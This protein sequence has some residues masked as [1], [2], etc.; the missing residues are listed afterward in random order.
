MPGP[1]L[2]TA[3]RGFKVRLSTLDNFLVA[4]GKPHGT[5]TGTIPPIYKYDD[6]GNA[7]DE[8]SELLRAQAKGAASNSDADS[9]KRIL[10]VIPSVEGHDYSP[11]AYIAYSYA[12]V[13]AHR[14][15][16]PQDPSEQI[17]QGFEELRQ[18]ILNYSSSP[19]YEH[20]GLIGLFIVITEGRV[21]QTPSELRQRYQV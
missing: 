13:Y 8:V 20:E 18:D 2:I 7:T 6:E 19:D 1:N 4:H 17:P 21:G 11:W 15:V 5:N 9:L 16:T 10:L 3:L 12:Q 14:H